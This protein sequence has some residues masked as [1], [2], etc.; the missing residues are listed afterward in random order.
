MLNSVFQ[1]PMLE[2][3][4]H[5]ALKKRDMLRHLG[6]KR[7]LATK[8]EQDDD[9]LNTILPM[10]VEHLSKRTGLGGVGPGGVR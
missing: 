2:K 7:K 5:L 8:Q 9:A 3:I 6:D 10:G 4:Y 1:G